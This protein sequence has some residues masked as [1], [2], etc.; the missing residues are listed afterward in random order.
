MAKFKCKKCGH[1]FETF[2]DSALDATKVQCD[3]CASHWVERVGDS[4]G[5]VFP[6]LPYSDPIYP[7][8][9]LTGDKYKFWCNT[10]PVQPFGISVN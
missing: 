4:S 6:V 8:P 10:P 5:F 2:C 9:N 7:V 1:V 3:Q